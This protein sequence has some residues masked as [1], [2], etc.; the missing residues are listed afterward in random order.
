MA[1]NHA[2]IKEI[3]ELAAIQV[4]DAELDTLGGELSKILSVFDQLSQANT[5]GIEPMVH[6]LD[7]TQPL[8]EDVVTETDQREQFQLLAPATENGLYLVPKVIE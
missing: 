8:R 1:L 4:T 6:P 3:A 2:E 5:Q 7:Q